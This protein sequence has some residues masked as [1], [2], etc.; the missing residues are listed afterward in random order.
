MRHDAEV[1]GGGEAD[2]CFTEVHAEGGMGRGCGI[3]GVMEIRF[4]E[5]R[6]A[7]A[8]MGSAIKLRRML[9]VYPVFKNH[10]FSM[11]Y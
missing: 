6:A 7:S 3:D 8:G 10:G 5:A 2:A 11:I 4:Q 1:V 9:I